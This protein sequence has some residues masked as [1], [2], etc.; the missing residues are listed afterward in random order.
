MTSERFPGKHLALLGGKPVL[1]HCLERCKQIRVAK[2]NIY[3][4]LQPIVILAVPD[5]PESVPLVELADRLNVEHFCGSEL[6][7]LDR[8]YH[9][10]MFHK[11]DIVVRITGDCPFVDPRVCSECVQLLQWRNLD[12][13][14]NSFPKRTYPKGLD[15]EVFTLDCLEAAHKL[16]DTAEDSE[17]VTPWMQRT[18][19]IKR[20]NVVQKID[21]SARNLCVDYPWDIERLE[22]ETL[23]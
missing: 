5:L 9:A 21:M 22:K 16:S 20:G 13:V 17:H 15:C 4:P 11:L 8:M 14:S 10:A 6:D 2:T 1:E 19:E 18:P 3:R 12:Y 23:P 7:V